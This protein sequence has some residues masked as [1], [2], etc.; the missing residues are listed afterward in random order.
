MRKFTKTILLAAIALLWVPR[1]ASAQTL[2]QLPQ[3]KKAA[4]ASVIEGYAKKSASSNATAAEAATSRPLGIGLSLSDRMTLEKFKAE[5]GKEPASRSQK[6]PMRNPYEP[7]DDT[8]YT[9]VGFNSY[10]GLSDD[11]E[12]VTGGM[13]AFNVNPFACDTISS[14]DGVSPYSYVAKGK[15]YCFLPQDF[16][17]SNSTE[18][19]GSICRTTYD[20][21]TVD[22]IEQKT[23]SNPTGAI[24]RVPYLVSYD[25]TRDIVYVI[26]MDNSPTNG[27]DTSYY[28]NILDT[29]T[30][31][32]KRIGYIGGYKMNREKGNFSPKSFVATS[33]TFYVLNDD[34]LY[35]EK[36]NPS[37]LE[38]TFIGRTEMPIK[39]T[40]GLQPMV[41]DSSTASLYVMHYDLENGTQWYKI[42]TYVGYG[43]ADK[44]LKT[45]LIE[46][47]PTGY[48]YFYNR[49]NESSTSTKKTL[50]DV[51]DLKIEVAEGSNTANISFTIPTTYADGTA[52]EVPSGT[53][54]KV[55]CYVYV[56]NTYATTTGLPPKV[57]YGTQISCSVELADGLHTVTVQVYPEWSEIDTYRFSD[58]ICVGY[59]APEMVENAKLR[60]FN[61]KASI[62]WDAPTK[63]VLEDFG[64]TFDATYLTYTIV[65]EFDGKVV[66]EDITNTNCTDGDI[67]D[68]MHTYSY[69]ITAKSHGNAG[70][71]A[72]TNSITYGTYMS[73]PYFNDFSEE[74]LFSGFTII[75]SDNN[76]TYRTW[77]WNQH[78]YNVYVNRGSSDDWLITPPF[79]LSSDYLYTYAYDVYGN[80]ELTTTVGQDN[81]VAGQDY[82]LDCLKDD[83][84]TVYTPKEYYFHPTVDSTYY[85]GLHAYNVS[86][87]EVWAVDNMAVKAIAPITAPDKIRSL[88]ITPDANGALGA[89]LSFTL[90]AT[91][92]AGNSLTSLEKVSIYDME[93]NLLASSTSVSPSASISLPITAE[94]GWN[95]F[96][97]V[98]ANADG[99]GWPVV[100]SKFIGPDV[101]KAPQNVKVCWGEEQNIASLSWEAS[102]EGE[103]GGY[104]NPAA[105]TYK[106]Y[107]YTNWYPAYE[108]LSDCGNETSVDVQIVDASESQN[109]YVFGVT[110]SNT[111]GESDYAQEGVILGTPYDIPFVEP[112]ASTGLDHTPWLIMAGINDESWTSDTGYFNSK[113]QPQN[114]DGL[115]LIFRNTGSKD[116]SSLFI[117]PI[118]DFTSAKNPVLSVWLHHSDAMP[119][120]AYVTVD[121]S[122]DGST[123]YVAASDTIRL[124]GNN[125]WT[126]HYF[127]LS[128]LCGK[129]AHV[130]L[131]A[132]LP[133]PSFR[134]F[135]DNWEI[136]EAE[137]NDLA[138]TAISQPYM[139]VVGDTANIAVTIANDGAVTASEYSVLFTLNGEVIAEE[140]AAEPLEIGQSATFSFSFPINAATKE[141]IYSAELMYD[142]DENEENNYSTEIELSPEQTDFPAPTNL[143]L[144]GD[145]ALAWTAP[146]EMDG[147]EIVL[148]CEDLPAFQTDDINGWTTYDEDEHLTTSFMTLYGNY[149]PYTQRPLAWMTWSA[150]EAGADGSQTWRPYE[151]E[152]CLISWGSYDIDE[153]GHSVEDYTSDWLI[154]PEIKGGTEFSFMTLS[155]DA[156]STMEILTSSTTPD[157]EAFTNKVYTV[158][159]SNKGEWYSI[160]T[161]L[162]AD[163]KYVA[164][165]T[166]FNGF[167]IMVDNVKYT[168]AKAPALLG[169]SLYMDGASQSFLT[170]TS[171]TAEGYGS[172]AVSAIYD[173][174]ESELSNAVSVIN[175]ISE[176]G[177]TSATVRGGYHMITIA[178]TAGQ[179]VEIFA[180]GGQQVASTVAA[181]TENIS[182][183]AGLYIAN[184]G[185]K[186]HKVIVK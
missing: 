144:S 153:A 29:A 178:G 97:V 6:A 147:H 13:V 71:S 38:R 83:L 12:T 72:S 7:D 165:H 156:T 183:P 130:G 28:L 185:G 180:A 166:L 175:A 141:Y 86:D 159:Y 15:L 131:E 115:Q 10:A 88:T 31:S 35:I 145:D 163:A 80:G 19:Y 125:G 3:D 92:I 22:R 132:Y 67:T 94:H 104:V 59:D 27:D 140:E 112:F 25:G 90:P 152:K 2:L 126:K 43:V 101:P 177:A 1:M 62:S 8:E 57:A 44:L 46:S 168:E 79:K 30:C 182:L 155:N 23:F 172:Y 169:Y 49:L 186:T 113:I 154:S 99:E 58:V 135:A 18:T 162:P 16:N 51:D 89:T 48:T 100:D 176:L 136:K 26:S 85:F 78:Y 111:E 36:L 114:E 149:W 63:G 65:R 158:G 33:G 60:F 170:A 68:I 142:A 148:G 45:E 122:T 167:G 139:P 4:S 5:T 53:S 181:Q 105:L 66:A 173:L 55:R 117:T 42:A 91:D 34:S 128:N 41:Y 9:Y 120:E 40:Y 121:A 69:A 20:A 116:G 106:V 124:T 102:T 21:S 95:Y 184:V 137:G 73:L 164:I 56:D 37:T 119:E 50:G 174:G 84:G 82:E 11:G 129:K 54:D 171:A 161:T 150:K 81:T 75:N 32:L 110:A 157:P 146:E 93:G 123:T 143:T 160:S 47:L 107:K 14:D 17:Y 109:Q 179:K 70:R 127:N 151:G 118:I 64:A 98:A 39:Y 138:L 103:N 133:N 77:M 61:G 87:D 52:I 24:D 74:S 108:E 96:K 134:I 76:G